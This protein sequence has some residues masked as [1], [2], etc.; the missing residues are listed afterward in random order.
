MTPERKKEL[1]L[2]EAQ[3][4]MIGDNAAKDKVVVVMPFEAAWIDPTEEA[5]ESIRDFAADKKG[6]VYEFPVSKMAQLEEQKEK[7][8]KK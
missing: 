4:H 6:S 2:K 1:A 3:K 7:K 8:S 5:M